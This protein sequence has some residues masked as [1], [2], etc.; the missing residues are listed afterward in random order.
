[1]VVIAW[2]SLIFLWHMDFCISF[3]LLSKEK[4][5]PHVT[6]L[7]DENNAYGRDHAIEAVN[8]SNIVRSILKKGPRVKP[9]DFLDTDEVLPPQRYQLE[10]HQEAVKILSKDYNRRKQ[11]GK[12]Q[13]KNAIQNHKFPGD[14]NKKGVEETLFK[15]EKIWQE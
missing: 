12:Q 4:L 3:L 14:G 11:G 7:Y 2:S 9:H 15:F 6:H 10:D 5:C 8:V 1:M 13:R